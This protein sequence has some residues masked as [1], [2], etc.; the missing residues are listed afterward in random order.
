MKKMKKPDIL[1]GDISKVLRQLTGP[2]IIGALGIV[3]FNLADTYFVGRIGTLEIAALSFTFP[4]VLIIN[5]LILGVGV[6][7]SAVISNAVGAKDE[8]KVKRLVT[9]SLLMGLLIALVAMIIGELTIVPLFTLLGADAQVMPY[10]ISYMRIWYA[11]AMFLA[12]PMVG[13]SAIRAL[14]DTKTPS[15]VMMVSA[16][17]NIV[18]DPIMIFGLGGFEGLGVSGAAIATVCSRFITFVVAMYVLIIREKAVTFKDTKLA[19]IFASWK[20]ILFIGMPNALARMIL[21]IG[22]GIITGLIARLGNDAVAGY[23]IATKIEFLFFSVFMALASVM[24][25]FV[26]QNYGAKQ[27]SRIL[28]GIRLSEKF[29]VFYGL[30]VFVVMFIAAKPVARLFSDNERVV[31]VI[32]TYFR[33]VPMG[34]GFYGIM[35]VL[36]SSYNALKKPIKAASINLI[37]VL[38]VFVPLASLTVNLLGIYGVFG[39]L[40]L[41][42]ILVSVVYHLIWKRD[43]L[44]IS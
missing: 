1:G 43:S 15:M 10:L 4:V 28:E 41:S 6:G 31:E 30:G 21:P 44:V 42:Y 3:A 26:G 33:I 22:A 24:P 17:G 13:N 5:S 34:Y 35:Q 40:A 18:L 14:G 23:G 36:N 11:G 25:I 12:V 37:Q 9:A 32:V 39:A 27:F 19:Q 29:S 20:S 38:A 16:L 8:H 2:M 7:A